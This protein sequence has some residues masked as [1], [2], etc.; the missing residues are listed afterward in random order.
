MISKTICYSLEGDTTSIFGKGDLVTTL[1]K[2]ELLNEMSEVMAYR[3][4]YQ[5]EVEM[6]SCAFKILYGRKVKDIFTKQG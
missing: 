3:L 4:N 2:S 6:L 1:R 5:T